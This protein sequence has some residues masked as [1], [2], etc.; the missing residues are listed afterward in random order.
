MPVD[1]Y[2]TE[3][4]FAVLVDGFDDDE[5]SESIW[6]KTGE[7]VQRDGKLV[8]IDGTG[9][10][11]RQIFGTH[12][13]ISVKKQFVPAHTVY[14]W[15]VEETE[16]ETWCETP[17]TDGWRTE[18]IAMWSGMVIEKDDST[19]LK[20]GS[21]VNEINGIS[22]GIYIEKCV[23]GIS[24]T[25]YMNTVSPDIS[26]DDNNMYIYT[27]RVTEGK[28][29][30]V[31]NGTKITSIDTS[32]IDRYRIRMESGNAITRMDDFEAIHGYKTENEMERR[33]Q[34]AMRGRVTLNEENT[35]GRIDIKKPIGNE[36]FNLYMTF[37]TG[38]QTHKNMRV[39]VY[40]N[41]SNTYTD[42]TADAENAAT[43]NDVNILPSPSDINDCMYLGMINEN[44]YI[45][46]DMYGATPNN[47][48][49]MVWEKYKSGENASPLEV[50]FTH[51]GTE[52]N[53]YTVIDLTDVSDYTVV[54]GDKLVFDIYTLDDDARIGIYLRTNTNEVARND[55]KRTARKW[56]RCETSLSTIVGKT[57][58]IFGV[59]GENDDVGTHGALIRNAKIVSSGGSTQ[60]NIIVDGSA[61]GAW[62]YYSRSNTGNSATLRKPTSTTD[63]IACDHGED[64]DIND[65][66]A[67]YANKF[68]LSKSGL[69]TVKN[70]GGVTVNG[71]TRYWIRARA[72][73]GTGATPK[74]TMI[75]D[76]DISNNTLAGA[77]KPGSILYVE[78]YKKVGGRYTSKPVDI[79]PYKVDELTV[80]PDISDMLCFD[81]VGIVLRLSDKPLGNVVIPYE[82]GMIY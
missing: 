48:V 41:S 44:G 20:V 60:R 80:V 46:V 11:S 77:A 57:V 10:R 82:G 78:I 66:T 52:T 74:A 9:V 19:Y 14:G 25:Q 42:F 32:D 17:E 39:F 55:S 47:S 69:V 68:I 18:D 4:T 12:E 29:E 40:D 22:T 1:P 7:P 6:E 23:E 34:R 76:I 67:G 53:K 72:I 24:D 49:Y 28:T 54:E 75:Y 15:Y 16:E 13:T 73:A 36:R 70:T 71:I 33:T 63:W 65:E 43:Q 5:V 51:V 50:F 64:G 81:D 26:N 31:L 8:L 3:P 2:T 59:V 27:V 61:L 21:I 58:T 62:S 37:E 45:Y 79:M 56:E 30:I 35:W 38:E